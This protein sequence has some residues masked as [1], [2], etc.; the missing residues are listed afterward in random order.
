MDLGYKVHFKV[1]MELS[2]FIMGAFLIQ[3]VDWP[4][5]YL[6]NIFITQF[7]RVSRRLNCWKYEVDKDISDL[8]K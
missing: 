2:K 8:N 1:T 6:R 7:D 4:N 5:R 3:Q